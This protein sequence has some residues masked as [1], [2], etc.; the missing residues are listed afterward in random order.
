MYYVHANYI[1]I[2]INVLL[3]RLLILNS[4]SYITDDKGKQAEHIQAVEEFLR[5]NAQG[6]Y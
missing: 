1:C 2:D 4:Y 3:R 5:S 6:E